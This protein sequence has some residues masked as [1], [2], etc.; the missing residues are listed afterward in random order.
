MQNEKTQK[1]QLLNELFSQI[2]PHQ[3][4]ETFQT[5]FLG[6]ITTD[7]YCSLNQ[8]D[9]HNIVYVATQL[10]NYFSKISE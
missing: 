6:Y 7:D 1:E 10:T 2:E 9:R 8:N 4:Q 3:A 5:I